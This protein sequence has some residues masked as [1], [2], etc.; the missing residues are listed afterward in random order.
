MTFS[1]PEGAIDAHNHLFAEDGY[2]ERHIEAAERLGIRR[3]VVCGLGEPWG[4]LDNAGI[5][6]A[7][8]RWPDRL[9]PLSF[10]RLGVD[11]AG[12]VA[13]ARR[14]GFVGLKLS[15]PPFP[16]DDERALPV[17]EKAEER[18]LPI[19]FH[20]GV[21]AHVPGMLTSAE[22]MRPLRLDGV[23]RR[24][25]GLKIQIAHLGVPE[26]ECAA[27]LARIV[28]NIYADA[29]GSVRG[30][31]ASKSPAFFRSL[32]YW[33]TWHRK[34]LFGTDVRC[35]LLARSL[36]QHTTLLSELALADKEVADLFRDNAR[37]FYGELARAPAESV[38]MERAV[39][40]VTDARGGSRDGQA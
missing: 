23:A 10:I 28:P 29:S 15:W 12:S 33:P 30:W 5:L 19:L 27:T 18:G 39:S 40:D 2:V 13:D 9:I 21:I 7:A 34:I 17:Y 14:Q 32:F 31:L 4:Q 22:Y 11:S 3:T 1:L 8:E 6:A 26:F 38:G 25:P 20:C 35:E 37:E 24:F 16:Y 36:E